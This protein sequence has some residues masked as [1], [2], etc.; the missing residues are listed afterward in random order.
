[1]VIQL[2]HHLQRYGLFEE[3]HSGFR[4]HHSTETA[5]AKFTN[6]LL[7]ASNSG[8]IS[9]LV[10]LDLSSAFDTDEHNILLKIRTHLVGIKGSALQWVESYLS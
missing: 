8:L 10:L 4:A 6:N 3:I 9:V 1:M 7:M 2:T 5:L